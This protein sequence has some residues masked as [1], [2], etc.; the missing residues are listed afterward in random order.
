MLLFFLRGSGGGRGSGVC[1]LLEERNSAFRFDSKHQLHLRILGFA[2]SGAVRFSVLAGCRSHG[3]QWLAESE[4]CLRL[5]YFSFGF[6]RWVGGGR[7]CG[8]TGV[9]VRIPAAR[10]AARPRGPSEASVFPRPGWS[11]GAAAP[12]R[13]GSE[14]ALRGHRVAV[15]REVRRSGSVLGACRCREIGDRWRPDSR[16]RPREALP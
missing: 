10:W 2:H 6:A 9:R 8:V 7:A 5:G 11:S 1:F 16:S 15:P 13:A 3:K 4:K 14:R 12:G